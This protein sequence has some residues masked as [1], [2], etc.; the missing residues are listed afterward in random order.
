MHKYSKQ[1]LATEVSNRQRFTQPAS[2]DFCNAKDL[3]CT[4]KTKK[5][6]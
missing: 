5:K 3:T 4:P 6:S 2:V 1:K